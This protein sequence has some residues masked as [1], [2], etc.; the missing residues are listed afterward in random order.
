MPLRKRYRCRYCG[1]YLNAYLP[2]AKAPNSAL[3]LGHLGQQHMDYLR[4]YLKRME[5][6]CI[7]RVLL[8]LFELVE[9]ED[10]GI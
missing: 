4:P 5:R 1:T 6:E 7:D 8:E 9:R 2:W 3:L 10:D